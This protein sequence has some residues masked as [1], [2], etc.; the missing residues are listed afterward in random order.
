MPLPEKDHQINRLSMRDEVYAKLLTWIM[1]GV[2][3]PGEKLVDKE[4]AENM[5]VSRTPVREAFRR[6]E[7]KG[8]VES[9]ASRW[10]RVSEISSDEPAMIYPIIWTLE[11]LAVSLAMKNLTADDLKKMEQ[12]NAE[13][14]TALLADDPVASS[15]ADASFHDIFIQKSENYH[16]VNILQDL[17]IMYRRLEIN[18]FEG[19]TRVTNSVEEHTRILAALKNKDLALATQILRTNWQNS[20]KRLNCQES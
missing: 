18:Y 15:Q 17:K 5:G 13:L 16:L 6:L 19:Y 7:D 1:E 11:E 20:L 14:K 9:S 10:T 8:L 2:F 3:R 12:A 4:L